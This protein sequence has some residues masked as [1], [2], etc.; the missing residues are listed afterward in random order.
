MYRKSSFHPQ[1]AGREG[2]KDRQ[3][4]LPLNTSK[5]FKTGRERER[6]RERES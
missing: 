2:R 1:T 6:E 4:S 5:V 3:S